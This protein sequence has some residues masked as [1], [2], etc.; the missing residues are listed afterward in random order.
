MV[1]NNDPDKKFI[2]TEEMVIKATDYIPLI[3]KD[4]IA[5]I[6]AA[7]C[8][9]EAEVGIDGERANEVLALPSIAQENIAKKQMYL[10]LLLLDNYLHI[11]LPNDFTSEVCDEFAK[12]HPMNQLER[13]KKGSDQVRNKVFDIISDFRE[14]EKMINTEI[15]NLKAVR[16]STIDRVLAGI[17]VMLTPEMVQKM[18]AELQKTI[19]EI[20]TT[21]KKITEKK[22]I[23]KKTVNKEG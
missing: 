1:K 16:N 11:K 13:L 14:L 4:A 9:D 2:I 6:F 5:K 3:E 18:V 19:G 23:T 20:E 21:Q 22:A 15:F 8:L 10:T 12:F 7:N 17:G